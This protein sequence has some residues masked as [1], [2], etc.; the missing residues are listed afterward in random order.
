VIALAGLESAARRRAGGYSLGM[1]QRLGIAAV[2]LGDP[3]VL[4]GDPAVLIGDPAVLI[5]G[6]GRVIADTPVSDL[7]TIQNLSSERTV[8]LLTAHAI[9]FSE[10]TAGIIIKEST[11][12][13]SA[14]GLGVVALWAVGALLLGALALQLRDA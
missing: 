1:R 11:S 10:V 9:P 13:G 3:A 12:Q 8:V 7:L 5:V 4:I 2:L 14:Y 6:R